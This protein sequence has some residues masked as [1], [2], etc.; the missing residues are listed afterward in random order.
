MKRVIFVGI[1]NSIRSQ[2]AEAFSGEHGAGKIVACSAGI[3]PCGLVNP[4]AVKVM[5]E[6]GYD[7][8]S[9]GSKSLTAFKGKSFDI[10]VTIGCEHECSPITAR[11]RLHW[12]IPDAKD[13]MFHDFRHVRDLIES[14]VMELIHSL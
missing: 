12:N 10:A 5:K 4:K 11:T 14:N 3:I 9:Q 6:L 8:S 13:M 7:L 2:I 1:K